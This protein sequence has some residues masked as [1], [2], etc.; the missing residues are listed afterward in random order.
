MVQN[1]VA[2]EKAQKLP[3]SP[4]QTRTEKTS[5][6][7]S[8]GVSNNDATSG[9]QKTVGNKNLQHRP[10]KLKDKENDAQRRK[11][12][13]P[14]KAGFKESEELQ[15]IRQILNQG[16]KDRKPSNSDN[17]SKE[18]NAV[19]AQSPKTLQEGSRK[20]SDSKSSKSHK[21]VNG[22]EKTPDPT[23]EPRAKARG[24][25]AGLHA[26][27]ESRKMNFEAF[28]VPP[29]RTQQGDDQ[30]NAGTQQGER[31]KRNK[32]PEISDRSRMQDACHT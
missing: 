3:S 32:K 14:A 31:L 26:Y 2:K 27:V 10:L 29:D 7:K 19:R 5:Q 18:T 13:P 1:A 28:E 21:A 9:D 4:E 23:P 6:Q 11:L 12:S 22:V 24:P 16:K 17:V 15:R 8:S 30:G 20:M 25:N